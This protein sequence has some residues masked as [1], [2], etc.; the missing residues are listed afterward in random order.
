MKRFLIT[1]AVGFF[2][3]GCNSD[4]DNKEIVDYLEDQKKEIE[5]ENDRYNK[6]KDTSK[7]VTVYELPE[8][9]F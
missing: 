3:V 8:I 4:K 6:F 1:L 7:G 9:K 2:L 5:S